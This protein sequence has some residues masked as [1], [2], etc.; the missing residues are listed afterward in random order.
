MDTK[1]VIRAK[2]SLFFLYNVGSFIAKEAKV[3]IDRGAR[4]GCKDGFHSVKEIMM[5]FRRDEMKY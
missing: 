3:I 2:W 4:S 1:P 5:K